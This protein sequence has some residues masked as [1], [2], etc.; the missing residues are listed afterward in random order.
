[1]TKQEFV[2]ANAPTNQDNVHP[3]LVAVECSNIE[4]FDP[5]FIDEVI[6]RNGNVLNVGTYLF[7]NGEIIQFT[8]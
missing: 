8:N 7:P 3:D 2:G 4:G 5:S 1:M 6:T